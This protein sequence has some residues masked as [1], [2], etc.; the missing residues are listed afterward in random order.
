[1]KKIIVFFLLS[2]LLLSCAV[3]LTE[4]KKAALKNELAE[5]AKSDQIAA[6]M[7]QG[8]YKEY[9]QEQWDNF[10]DSVFTSDKQKA[11]KIFNKYGFPGFDK[12]DKEGSSNFWLVVQHCDKYP[13]FQKKVL[14]E[15][16]KEIKKNNA[17]P[18]NYA[19]LYD[20]VQINAKQKQK[21]GTQL[22]Y[23]VAK[24]GR[25][26]PKIGLIDSIN[27]DKIRKAY[28]LPPLKD[29][30]NEM[31]LGHY[32]MNKAHYQK[33]GLTKADLYL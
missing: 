26:I 14:I 10:K 1:M 15:M 20:R 9:T 11:E 4:T 29:Y 22:T 13:D 19:Y 27:V 23:D 28:D 12:V 32:E 16:D 2:T 33:M 24:T 18:K 31:T 8:K 25:A 30:L 5:M 17:N 6:S 7:P 3:K 21:F